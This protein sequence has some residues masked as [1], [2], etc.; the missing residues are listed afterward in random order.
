ML[1][2]FLRL[3]FRDTAFW[4]GMASAAPAF[5]AAVRRNIAHTAPAH[6][7]DEA[8]LVPPVMNEDALRQTIR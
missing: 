4:G 2:L 8:E 3:N 7:T 6:C 5:Y 1:R